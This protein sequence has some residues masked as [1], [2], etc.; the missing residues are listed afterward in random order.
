M[1]NLRIRLSL[2][3]LCVG[4]AGTSSVY[5]DTPVY[6]KD[7]LDEIPSEFEATPFFEVS[8]ESTL[9]VSGSSQMQ[10]HEWIEDAEGNLGK[11][12][13]IQVLQE[14]SNAWDVLVHSDSNPGSL[15]KGDWVLASFWARASHYSDSSLLTG[16]IERTNPSW[17]GIASLGGTAVGEWRR[18]IGAGQVEDDYEAGSVKLSLH[19][20]N[21]IQSI[22]I[23]GVSMIQLNDQVD[24]DRLPGSKISYAG[25]ALDA[26][27]R[28]TA[29]QMIEQHRKGQMRFKL[30]DLA[31]KPLSGA[32]VRIEQVNHAYEFGTFFSTLL[33]EE[34]EG[35]D[36]YRQWLKDN[37]N[38]ATAPIYWAD[39]GW[40]DPVKRE[41]Y[42]QMAAWLQEQGIPTRGHV[43]LYPGWKFAPQELRDLSG[44]P[45]AFQARI[46]Q[47][48]EEIVPI[49][50]AYGIREY[51]VTN[52]LRQLTEVTGIVGLKGVVE[53]F[54]KVRELD[55]EAILYIN[56]NTILS[57]GASNAAAQDHYFDTIQTLLD[58]GAPIDG[59]G[60][61]G[62]FTEAVTEPER[63]WEVLDRFSVYDLP[64]RVTEYDLTTRDEEGQAR[65]DTDFYTAIFAH[66]STVG[67]TRWGYFE[68]EMWRPLGA[69]V[70]EDGSYKANGLAQREL[71]FESWNTQEEL[72]ASEAGTIQLD[73]FYGDY[74][75]LVEWKGEEIEI[76]V[77]FEAEEENG[78]RSLAMPLGKK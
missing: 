28:E 26:P 52:E 6:L 17:V 71:L 27:W 23:A 14:S 9:S 29:Q 11:F 16:Y 15:Q 18:F 59:I 62:H 1:L 30:V 31:G 53:W 51:D 2:L 33:L 7:L 78:F 58:M 34:G 47:H 68:P 46:I 57:D 55:P 60:M 76:Q 32:N 3:T 65:Y 24:P 43:L 40:A 20:A 13:R 8:D 56:E 4:L 35:G 64:I 12:V 19:L 77:E 66:P 44:D 42:K 41:E 61:Q 36:R 75:L 74:R 25:M 38:H 49:M 54:H 70:G 73:A 45:E 22:D 48:F 50:K 69:I 37:F 21:G 5:P 67:L 10:S 39:W 72:I 63:I